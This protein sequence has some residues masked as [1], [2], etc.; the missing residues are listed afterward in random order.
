MSEKKK[1]RQ[2]TKIQKIKGKNCFSKK[3]SSRLR[4][5]TKFFCFQKKYFSQKKKRPL[6]WLTVLKN[7]HFQFCLQKSIGNMT[8][9][10][11]SKNKNVDGKNYYKLTNSNIAELTKQISI[12]CICC[13]KCARKSCRST[14]WGIWRKRGWIYCCYESCDDA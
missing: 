3:I 4:K 8:P 14:T 11:V 7:E 10:T 5:K 2:K 1:C 13:W 6:N 9:P 12:L